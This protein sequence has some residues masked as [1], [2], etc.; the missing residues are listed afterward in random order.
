MNKLIRH[1]LDVL[2]SFQKT[3]PTAHVGGSIGLLIR[4]VNLFRD[5]SKSDLDITIDDFDFNSLDLSNY[6]QRS[7]G[8]DFDYAIKKNINDGCYV[9]IDIRVCPEPSF[10]EIIFEGNKF[11]V[12]KYRDIIFWKTKYSLKGV[13]KHKEDLLTIKDG[14]RKPTNI[15]VDDLPY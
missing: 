13:Q 7:H 12:S 3:Y 11:N 15:L 2:A 1:K 6:E 8:N 9:K 14:F 5:L 10:E 4:G